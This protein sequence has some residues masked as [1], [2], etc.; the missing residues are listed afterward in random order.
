MCLIICTVT[1]HW[2]PDLTQL[3]FYRD[4]TILK[5]ITATNLQ[6]QLLS[7]SMSIQMSTSVSV[8]SLFFVFLYFWFLPSHLHEPM[9][10][11]YHIAPWC[12]LSKMACANNINHVQCLHTTPWRCFWKMNMFVKKKASRWSR[13]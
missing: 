12:C 13:W 5:R 4:I 1:L 6:W 7:M 3:A 2:K 10:C 8:S 11:R 9:Q